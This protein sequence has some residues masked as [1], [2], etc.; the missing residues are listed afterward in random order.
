VDAQ[1]HLQN[2]LLPQKSRRL[3]A[4]TQEAAALFSRYTC[5]F[6]TSR[7]AYRKALLERLLPI[8]E[9]AVIVADEWLFTLAPWLADVMVLDQALFYYRLHGGNMYMLNGATEKGLR[10]M[11]NSLA[12]L[13]QHFPP[14][15]RALGIP[16]EIEVPL[17]ANLRLQ[18]S[19]LRLQ[20]MGGSRREVLEL[21]RATNDFFNRNAPVGYR[22]FKQLALLLTL[23]L[24]SKQF[25]RL[26]NWYSK[27]EL[28][29]VR[30]WLAKP[31]SDG[32]VIERGSQER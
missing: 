5:F 3:N 11:H 26:K 16:L 24:P 13:V 25:F 6:G 30:K 14:K 19:R 21:E 15:M 9:G 17:L 23:V 12:C 4:R 27:S 28:R 18:A 32:H 8:P 10:R 31:P 7:V 1:G 20:L 2:T 22:I 29:R